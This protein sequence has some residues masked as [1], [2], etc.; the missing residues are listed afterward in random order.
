VTF[1]NLVFDFH[2]ASYGVPAK[3]IALDISGDNQRLVPA[4]LNLDI[5]HVLAKLMFLPFSSD[6][7]FVVFVVAVSSE[8]TCV[9]EKFDRS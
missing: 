7:E 6:F 9:I 1:R 5:P 8:M 3:S 4:M 2:L